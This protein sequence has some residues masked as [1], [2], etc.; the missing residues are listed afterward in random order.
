[1]RGLAFAA[2]SLAVLLLAAFLLVP[3]RFAPLFEPFTEYGAP[4]IY[5]QGSLLGLAVAHLLLVFAAT[6]LSALV[7]VGLAVFVTRPSGAEF[8]PLSRTL[9]NIDQCFQRLRRDKIQALQRFGIN[10]MDLVKADLAGQK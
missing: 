3:Q 5:D 10:G 2:R 1:M 7:A 4:P 8:L 9:V 6:A